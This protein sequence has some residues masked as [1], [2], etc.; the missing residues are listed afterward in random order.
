MS[1][2]G[3]DAPRSV[4]LKKIFLV[5]WPR[6]DPDLAKDALA[7]LTDDAFPRHPIPPVDS[8]AEAVLWIWA[9]LIEIDTL[10][11]QG[12]LRRV[13]GAGS[14]ISYDRLMLEVR[15]R[16]VLEAIANDVERG[17]LQFTATDPRTGRRFRPDPTQLVGLTGPDRWREQIPTASGFIKN[18]RFARNAAHDPGQPTLQ[19]ATLEP[20]PRSDAERTDETDQE[21]TPLPEAF[22]ADYIT[23]RLAAKQDYS[24]RGAQRERDRRELSGKKGFGNTALNNLVA[25]ERTRRRHRQNRGGKGSIG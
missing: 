23:K 14:A 24:G 8:E 7:A 19:P 11:A 4:S 2:G 3:A 1:V 18:L 6:Y 21:T 22:V 15:V 13:G 20:T 17:D 25:R 9:E 16:K 12:Y 10:D 5:T